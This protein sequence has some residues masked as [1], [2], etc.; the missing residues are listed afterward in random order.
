MVL[1]GKG[2]SLKGIFGLM[3]VATV[4]TG[5]DSSSGDS[6][7]SSADSAQ[8]ATANVGPAVATTTSSSSS[9]GTSV[10]KSSTSTTSTSTAS[11]S[12]NSGSSST[13]TSSSSSTATST[14][15]AALQWNAPTDNAN[16]SAL[17]NLVGYNVYYGTSSGAMTNK[18]AINTVGVTNYVIQNMQSG[19]W[20]F[21]MT[22]VNSSGVESVMTNTVQVA[23]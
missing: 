2:N 23:L 18:I 13:G 17:T 11:T 4:L 1:K 14:G 9:G 8:I 15:T 5:C 19:T 16:G 22:A 21:A 3:I 10:S 12:S 6:S 20:Y 7:S